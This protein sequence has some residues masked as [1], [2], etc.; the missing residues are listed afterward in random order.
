MVKLKDLPAGDILKEQAIMPHSDTVVAKQAVVNQGKFTKKVHRESKAS[1]AII[2]YP[3]SAQALEIPST[4]DEGFPTELCAY[5]ESLK[6][7]DN[8]VQ[9]VAS[10]KYLA[11]YGWEW[12]CKARQTQAWLKD[13]IDTERWNNTA[14]AESLAKMGIQMEVVDGMATGITNK[15][16]AYEERVVLNEGICRDVCAILKH[17]FGINIIDTKKERCDSGEFYP[18]RWNAPKSTFQKTLNVTKVTNLQLKGASDFMKKSM[19]TSKMFK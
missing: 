16:L 15:G 17:T 6:T 1:Y 8:A 7:K 5:F 13:I 10:L 18:V 9:L 12:A 3:F 4:N 2:H 11:N 14:I 19:A